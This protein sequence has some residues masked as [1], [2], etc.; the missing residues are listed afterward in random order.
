[1]T[2]NYVP[3]PKSEYRCSRRFP[4][5]LM[6]TASDSLMTTLTNAGIDVD[7]RQ[8]F[9]ALKT[10]GGKDFDKVGDLD[11]YKS[12]GFKERDDDTSNYNSGGFK[13][14]DDDTKAKK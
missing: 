14:R 6:N 7:P 13:E 4:A 10:M 2:R 1:M 12:G 3:Q 5:V 9:A 8:A 11:D